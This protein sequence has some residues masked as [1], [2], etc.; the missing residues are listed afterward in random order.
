M[1]PQTGSNKACS[2]AF[3]L[4]VER[5]HCVYIT[6]RVTYRQ[7]TQLLD[8]ILMLQSRV[9]VQKKYKK[10]PCKK[11]GMPHATDEAEKLL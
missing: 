3:K 5:L 7:L 11:L 8:C 6:Q 9:L 1:L 4:K 2:V 10:T